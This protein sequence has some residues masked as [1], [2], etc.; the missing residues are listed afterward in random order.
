MLHFRKE[1]KFF[2]NNLIHYFIIM[3]KLCIAASPAASKS[4]KPSKSGESKAA[5][6]KD[7]RIEVEVKVSYFLSPSEFHVQLASA[8]KDGLDE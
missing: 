8:A 3:V 2:F 7:K 6:K 1:K 4:P 5:P